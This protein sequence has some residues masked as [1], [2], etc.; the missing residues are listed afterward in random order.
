MNSK[1][2]QIQ[3]TNSKYNLYAQLISTGGQASGKMLTPLDQRPAVRQQLPNNLPASGHFVYLCNVI[4]LNMHFCANF[5]MY[6][7]NICIFLQIEFSTKL[8]LK[9]SVAIIQPRWQVKYCVI[10]LY[11]FLH[12]KKDLKLK[13]HTGKRT[14]GHRCHWRSGLKS[15]NLENMKKIDK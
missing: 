11:T 5:L 14:V 4:F 10:F 13:A 12:L 15:S 1:R 6:L 3:H 8:Q 9:C 2:T 7:C